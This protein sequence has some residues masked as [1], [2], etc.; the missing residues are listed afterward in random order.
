[1]ATQL[2]R[3][4]LAGADR[5]HNIE[6]LVGVFW[7]NCLSLNDILQEFGT[8]TTHINEEQDDKYNLCRNKIRVLGYSTNDICQ[9]VNHR[10]KVGKIIRTRR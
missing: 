7:G 2:S 9:P 1:M 5:L 3:A 8:A 6:S 10:A 4:K